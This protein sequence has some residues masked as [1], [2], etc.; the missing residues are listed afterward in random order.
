MYICILDLSK[1]FMTLVSPSTKKRETSKTFFGPLLNKFI[2]NRP[3]TIELKNNIVLIGVI[4][5]IDDLLN[6][7]LEKPKYIG[8]KKASYPFLNDFD[9]ESIEYT[10]IRGSSIKYIFLENIK[11]NMDKLI[12]ESQKLTTELLSNT[13]IGPL[14]LS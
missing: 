5:E 2:E 4:R 12:K 7:K 11:S 6:V 10:Y 14:Q 13:D 1:N 3:I 9:G 8:D